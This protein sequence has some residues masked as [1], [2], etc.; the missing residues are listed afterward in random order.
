MKTR[1][2]CAEVMAKLTRDRRQS[3]GD[4]GRKDVTDQIPLSVTDIT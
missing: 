1:Q 3:H 4:A 2:E